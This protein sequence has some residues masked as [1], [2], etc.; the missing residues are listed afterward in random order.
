MRITFIALMGLVACAPQPNP[1]ARTTPATTLFSL[2]EIETDLQGNCFAKAADKT[3]VRVIDDIIQVAPERRDASGNVTDPA[4][5][6]R[7]TKPETVVIGPGPRFETLCPQRYAP[8]FVQSL[9]RALV[10]RQAYVGPINGNYDAQTQTAVRAQQARV[11]ID[12]ALLS[13]PFAREM[14]ILS[15][16]RETE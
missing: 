8:A 1:V 10:V 15:V 9:Q 14:G 11:G 12:S 7:V 4:V 13:V 6:R 3:Q 5:F 2:G 16:P